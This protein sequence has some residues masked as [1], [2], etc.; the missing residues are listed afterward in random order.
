MVEAVHTVLFVAGSLVVTATALSL[1]RGGFWWARLFDFPRLQTAALGLVVLIA[2]LADAP[3]STAELALV[4]VVGL[5][6]GYQSWCILPYTPLWRRQVL[7][8]EAPRPERSL[9]LLIANVFMENRNAEG[10][11]SLVRGADPD[12][13]LAMETDGFWAER[14]AALDNAYPFSLKHP[15]DNTYGMLLFS[16]LEL[17]DAEV[18]FLLEEEVPSFRARVVLRSGEAF[19]FYGVHPR[20]PYLLQDASRRD[21]ELLLVGRE[22]R[23]RGDGAGPAVVAGDLND[24]AWSHTTRLFQRISGLL[25]PRI[26]R[27]LY[28]TFHARHPLLRWPLDHVF[29]DDDF[30]LCRLQRLPAFGSDHFP[31]L[32]EVSYEPARA[33][34]QETP[35]TEPGNGREAAERIEEGRR[36]A[37]T[38]EPQI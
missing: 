34:E 18:R 23:E 14:L 24:V 8:A 30:R 31:I 3:T 33:H 32:V 17:R 25:D 35:E 11:L 2:L 6:V 27:G 5:A 15:R 26:G 37:K 22:I 10:L 9:C 1:V 7:G 28:S 12:M 29:F 38:E 36:Q 16:R 13:I 19:I 4:G 21:A 20:P